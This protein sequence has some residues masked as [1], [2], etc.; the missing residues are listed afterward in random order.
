[1]GTLGLG[2]VRSSG[3]N[4]SGLGCE[5]SMICDFR[6]SANIKSKSA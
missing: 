3:N 6:R 4:E 2:L 1:M 5:E